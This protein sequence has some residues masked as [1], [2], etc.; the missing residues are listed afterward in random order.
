MLKKKRFDGTLVKDLPAFTLLMPYLMTD[1]KGSIIYFQQDLDVTWTMDYIKE[2]NRK[3]IKERE[4]LTLFEVVMCAAARSIALR[5]RLNRFICGHRYY[6]RNQI[7]LNF[8]AKKEITD[9]GKEVNVKIPFA[10]DETLESVAKK[11]R[12]YVKAGLSDDGL[13]NEK[14]VDTLVKLPQGII[15]FVMGLMN[16]LDEHNLPVRSLVESD[17]MWASIFLANVGSFG[18]DAPFH[19]L[20]ERGNCPIFMAVGNLRM[21][22][23]LD[24]EGKPVARKRLMIRYSVDDRVAD[25]VYLGKG[26]D[27]VRD[28]IEHPEKL[29]VR[30]DLDPNLLAELKLLPIPE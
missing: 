11:T 30:P 20:F 25:G 29:A 16:W 10:P 27:L 18:L 4:I 28:F 3:L 19:H 2:T 24:K 17:P 21:V 15:K 6:Q 22:W 26:L 8:V 7:L 1:K 5:P 9:D 14:V 12:R 23:E 13:D